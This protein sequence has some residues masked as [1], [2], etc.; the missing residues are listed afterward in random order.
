MRKSTVSLDEKINVLQ[1]LPIFNTLREEDLTELADNTQVCVWEAGE[2]ILLD[3]AP[4]SGLYFVREGN[5]K[6]YK[7]SQH[8]REMV[9]RVVGAGYLFNEVAVIDGGGNPVN[10][11]A[12]QQ[13]ELWVLNENTVRAY[14]E[15]YPVL[16]RKVMSEMCANLRNLME[17]VEELSFYQITNRLARLIMRLPDE[18]LYGKTAQRLTQEE[19]ASH[20]GTVREVVARS[21]RELE[22]SGAIKVS[23]SGI[24]ISDQNILSVW[25]Q[26]TE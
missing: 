25:A 16:A 20:L 17:L 23:R 13:V 11:A 24:R 3:H 22:K 15:R 9:V 19:L 8:G 26:H 4:C 12:L 18:R 1:N 10:A 5:V 2:I 14:F 21:L 7:S 6:L